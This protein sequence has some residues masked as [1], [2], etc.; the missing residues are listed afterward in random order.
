MWNVYDVNHGRIGSKD[1]DDISVIMKVIVLVGWGG[2]RGGN[3]TSHPSKRSGRS[4][5][6]LLFVS[7]PPPTVCSIAQKFPDRIPSCDAHLLETGPHRSTYTTSH[8]YCHVFNILAQEY[9]GP[10]GKS[11][12][13]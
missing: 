9:Q 7:P 8:I 2:G 6:F 3:T 10:K 4:R 12:G 5:M 13:Y 11:L 1:P